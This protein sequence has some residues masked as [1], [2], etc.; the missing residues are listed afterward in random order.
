MPKK[1]RPLN[2]NKSSI[3]QTNLPKKI[4][5]QDV[6]NEYN[7]SQINLPKDKENDMKTGNAVSIHAN[8]GP[9]EQHVA[10][11]QLLQQRVHE[12]LCDELQVRVHD[13][14]HGIGCSHHAQAHQQ[15]QQG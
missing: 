1:K 6:L 14:Q 8:P 13:E 4:K 11:A 15:L 2:L 5:L 12:G 10:G 3:S 9:D 7:S